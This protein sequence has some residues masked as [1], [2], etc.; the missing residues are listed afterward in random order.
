LADARPPQ[1][2]AI[3]MLRQHPELTHAFATND[4]D[5]PDYVIVTVGVR[6]KGTVDLRIAKDKYDSLELLQIIEEHTS[7]DLT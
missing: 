6:D 7:G 4:D 1:N 3:N 5:D 2:Q